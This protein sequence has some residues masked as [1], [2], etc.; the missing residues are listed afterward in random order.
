MTTPNSAAKPAS[1]GKTR[2]Q[3]KNEAVRA[4]KAGEIV[5]GD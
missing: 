4:S 3:V 1:A 5:K 2:E